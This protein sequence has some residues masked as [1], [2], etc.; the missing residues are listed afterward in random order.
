MRS[1]LIAAAAAVGLLFGG[2]AVLSASAAPAPVRPSAAAPLAAEDTV[3]TKAIIDGQIYQSDIN[4]GVEAF[5]R[6][7]PANSVWSTSMNNGIVS[8]Q[9]LTAAV[10][11]K[12]ELGSLSGD[13]IAIQATPIAN[14]GG[15]FLSRSTKV[16][17]VTLQPGTW[18]VNTSAVFARV[19]A[20]AEGTRPQLALRYNK[21][22][23]QPFGEDAGTIMGAEISE[24]AG[25]ELT[26]S[27]VK[28]M[29]V[30]VPTVIDVHAFGYNDD[31]SSAGSGELTAAAEITA[32]RVG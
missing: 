31:T 18:L 17:E 20:G 10:K 32:L 25:R 1:R 7:T 16:G 8:E 5:L 4:D 22:E 24:A 2:S 29:T 30:S 12:L 21:T 13:P 26:G 14:I 6:S 23:A 3:G 27:S 11:A 15:S 28:A 19:T 9:K